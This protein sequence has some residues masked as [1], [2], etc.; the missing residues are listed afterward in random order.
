MR[1][2][3]FYFYLQDNI[4]RTV[5]LQVNIQNISG[6]KATFNRAFNL[7]F[8]SSCF[9]Q[10]RHH[11]SAMKQSDQYHLSLVQVFLLW[12]QLQ[13][14]SVSRVKAP[15]ANRELLYAGLELMCCC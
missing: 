11:S 13:P 6:T 12:K 10:R 4:G 5:Y 14:R 2:G 15:K 7:I 8:L 1:L 9:H 3:I